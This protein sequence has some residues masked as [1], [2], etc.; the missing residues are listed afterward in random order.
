MQFPIMET[1]T[2]GQGN[3]VR[4]GKE[5]CKYYIT[6]VLGL[7]ALTCVSDP[8]VHVVNLVI[9]SPPKQGL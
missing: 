1:A 8:G 2:E 4:N 7:G 6:W 3:L 9:L 5:N